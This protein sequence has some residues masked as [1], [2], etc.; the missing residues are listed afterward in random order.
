MPAT[1]KVTAVEP[2]PVV[3]DRASSGDLQRIAG[4]LR[5]LRYGSVTIIVQDGVLVQLER[6]EK[7]RV[8]QRGESSAR[9]S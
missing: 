2:S 8:A 3:E 9:S 6:T 5:G 1:T 4:A 7:V